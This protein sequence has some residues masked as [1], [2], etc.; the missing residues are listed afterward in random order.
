MKDTLDYSP[1]AGDLSVWPQLKLDNA[2]VKPWEETRAAALWVLPHITDVWYSMMTDKEGTLA[3]F[4]D[5]IPTCATDDKF[6]YINPG[7]YFTHSLEQRVFIAA[8]E[9][10]HCIFNHCGL[11][12]ALSKQGNVKYSDGDVLP[13]IPKLMNIAMDCVINAILVESKVGGVPAKAWLL[14]EINGN[15]NALEAYRIL[16]NKWKKPGKRPPPPG[17]KESEDDGMEI[18]VIPAGEEGQSFDKH[19]KP[20]TGRGK[21]PMEAESE[22][23]PQEW[24]D[25]VNAAMQ[26]ARAAGRLPAN[27]E[28]IFKIHMDVPTPWQDLMAISVSQS[29]GREGHS[30]TF[31]DGEFATRGIGFPGRMRHGC[32]CAVLA[33]DSSGST[34]PSIDM[35]LSNIAVILSQVNPKELW[36]TECDAIVHRFELLQD[37]ADL[38]SIVLGGG[39]TSVRPVFKRIEEEGLTPDVF[40]YFTDLDVYDGFPDAPEYPV[41]W[42]CDNDRVKAPWGETIYVPPLKANPETL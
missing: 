4:T 35:F 8:H 11:M 14:P 30:W 37:M 3:W 20:G 22:R 17:D 25:A 5:K 32:K 40:I 19:L 33:V 38:K 16:Y 10:L 23:N 21:T 24:E 12:Y 9:V 18:I 29:I 15:M 42:A 2:H 1:V 34:Q 31:L 36:F 41:I 26:S 6:M 28:R 27:M 39:G 7:F 13:Y